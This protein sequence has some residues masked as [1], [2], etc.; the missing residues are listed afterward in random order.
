MLALPRS[1]PLGCGLGVSCR[2]SSSQ[3]EPAIVSALAVEFE[4]AIADT[5]APDSGPPQAH[6]LALKSLVQVVKANQRLWEL[7]SKP[8]LSLGLL[9][10]PSRAE[11]ALLSSGC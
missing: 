7:R 5:V 8:L 1:A 10:L 9:E 4:S 11:P 3:F 6:R 2:S